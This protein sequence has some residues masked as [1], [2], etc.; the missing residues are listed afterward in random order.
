MWKIACRLCW[1][2][3]F[4]IH[5]RQCKYTKSWRARNQSQLHEIRRTSGGSPK[6]KADEKILLHQLYAMQ[7]ISMKLREKKI[8]RT[9]MHWT[10]RSDFFLKLQLEKNMVT[11]CTMHKAKEKQRWKLLKRNTILSGAV[12]NK[13]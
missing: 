10:K 1:K 11:H 3:S 9:R 13:E 2:H 8:G 6:N 7:R 5:G 12:K 4:Q